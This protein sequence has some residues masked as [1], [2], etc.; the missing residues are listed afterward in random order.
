MAPISSL[1]GV[2]EELNE[3]TEGK[4][5]TGTGICVVSGEVSE[6]SFSLEGQFREEGD[7]LTRLH[8]R[9]CQPYGIL[10]TAKLRD[11]KTMGG[12]RGKR[13]QMNR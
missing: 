1:T 7:N 10:E 2:K 12:Y 5:G 8:T 4:R 11:S 9:R 13:R 3:K 6:I